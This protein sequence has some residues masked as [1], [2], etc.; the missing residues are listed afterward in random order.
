MPLVGLAL[1]SLIFRIFLELA[2]ASAGDGCAGVFA[3]ELAL[4]WA[5]KGGFG[6]SSAFVLLAR[7]VSGGERAEALARPG[8]RGPQQAWPPGPLWLPRDWAGI[9]P[10]SPCAGP[11]QSVAAPW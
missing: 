11:S 1:I 2:G 8:G 4:A 10:C 9:E 5:G 6:G 7:H 3:E